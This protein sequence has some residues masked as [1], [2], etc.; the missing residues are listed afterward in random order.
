MWGRTI[1]DQHG[2]IAEEVNKAFSTRPCLGILSTIGNEIH[3]DVEVREGPV[4]QLVSK[5]CTRWSA[6]A[7]SDN[8]S[9]LFEHVLCMSCKVISNEI[10]CAN[11]MSAAT[12]NVKVDD[13]CDSDFSVQ[14]ESKT[15]AG[16]Q[17]EDTSFEPQHILKVK[18]EDEDEIN[19]KSGDWGL[20]DEIDQGE[21]LFEPHASEE[22]DNS[23][24]AITK[25]K[26]KCKSSVKR[27]RSGSRKVQERR[28][29][30]RKFKYT[31]EY[32]GPIAM[33]HT[34]ESDELEIISAEK[35][36]HEDEYKGSSA[37][38]K[39]DYWMAMIFPENAE[40][41][42]PFCQSTFRHMYYLTLH[43]KLKHAF[44]WYQ[45]PM[46]QIWRN[47][48]HEIISHCKEIH[49]K[50]EDLEFI[51]PCCK[52]GVKGNEFE[53]HAL[54]CFLLNFFKQKGT[55]LVIWKNFIQCR[56]CSE[57][58]QSRKDYLEHLRCK[59][60]DKIF[61]CS[62]EGC[63]FICVQ[64]RKQINVHMWIVHKEAAARKL[65]PNDP[66]AC[67]KCG[68]TFPNEGS[69]LNHLTMEHNTSSVGQAE[70]HCPECGDTYGSKKELQDH[71]HDIHLK[72]SYDCDKCGKAFKGRHGLKQHLMKVHDKERLRLQC[73]LCAEWA[74]N[75]ECL[76]NH[77]RTKHTG[78]KP[79]KCTFCDKAFGAASVMTSHR[80][81]RHPDSWREE[82][83]RRQWLVANKGADSSQYKMPCHLCD[84][85][86]GTI[87]ELR[88]HWN[89]EHPGMTDR[90]FNLNITQ[91][92][93]PGTCE[94]C[95]Q[96]FDTQ[97]GLQLHN[98]KMHND[99][100]NRCEICDI[101]GK[102][103]LDKQGVRAHKRIMHQIGK[104]PPSYLKSAICEVCGKSCK[105]ALLWHHMKTHAANRPKKCTYCEKEFP[106]YVNMIRHRKLAHAEQY[107]VDRD[108]L[109]VEEGSPNALKVNPA[110]KKWYQKQKM[111]KMMKKMTSDAVFKQ[112]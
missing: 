1:L 31:H 8:K 93:G 75:R 73:E 78:E 67:E 87:H 14:A 25:L 109:M 92:E 52:M 53:M 69:L 107:K 35:A 28:K 108:K 13:S 102:S 94:I 2:N 9:Q 22:E 57:S 21:E 3:N 74:P 65:N 34:G 85:T 44:D 63:N 41:I 98:T 91:G 77:M 97:S 49:D 64:D 29:Y 43:L 59:H 5:K 39:D 112:T 45:C 20:E 100:S 101:C 33:I 110:Y 66:I 62:W 56:L 68:R 106:S 51:C 61:K 24:G 40:L 50:V 72:L 26:E 55:G 86:R 81:Q 37:P 15:Y 6:E 99:V 105:P 76:D 46:C 58:M 36:P 48:P 38:F 4:Q 42:C 32:K 10:E 54:K 96:G 111:K 19:S 16:E 17:V 90:A 84:Q 89:A 12:R 47:R 104:P 95:G 60:D 23:D 83:K 11:P 18:I 79:F 70:A 27:K 88:A 82:K 7:Y 103:F 30:M 80:A 71:I